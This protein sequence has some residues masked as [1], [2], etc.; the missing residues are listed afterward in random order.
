MNQLGASAEAVARSVVRKQAFAPCFCALAPRVPAMLVALHRRVHASAW[1]TF[2]PTTLVVAL[3]A[4]SGGACDRGPARSLDPAPSTPSPTEAPERL[5][6]GAAI[7]CD[8]VVGR[9]G[10]LEVSARDTVAL[11]S[12]RAAIGSAPIPWPPDDDTPP[13]ALRLRDLIGQ[14]LETAVLREVVPTPSA[15]FDADDESTSSLAAARGGDT[16][17][18]RALLERAP[19]ARWPDIAAVIDDRLRFITWLDTQRAA[20]DDETLAV[21]WERAN[22][23]R[24][25]DIVLLPNAPSNAAID[26]AVHDR[27]AE[28]QARYD[29]RRG[30]YVAPPGARATI[31]RF[32][33]PADDPEARRAARNALEAAL[34]EG[35]LRPDVVDPTTAIDVPYAQYPALRDAVPGMPTDPQEDRGGF[36]AGVVHEHI[37]RRTLPLDDALRRQ[38]A[39]DLL[40]ATAIQPETDERARA[41]IAAWRDGDD[42]LAARLRAPIERIQ[43]T[44]AFAHNDVG[45]VP[46]AGH[47]P[48][49]LEALFA[50]QLAEGDLLDRPFLTSEGV[51]IVRMTSIERPDPERWERERGVVRTRALDRI[52]ASGWEEMLEV[53]FTDSPPHFDAETL[54]AAWPRC[55]AEHLASPPRSTP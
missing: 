13:D 29:Q 35:A 27:A 48:D 9:A 6:E 8:A 39:A 18:Q 20:L 36:W 42:A 10:E 45:S 30:M 16:E 43:R 49:L 55:L 44:P 23:R 34:S 21:Q 19:G 24:V 25:A 33:A 15:T 2:G 46:V 50:S 52:D 7:S 40:R 17:A 38:I 28:I 37:E 5:T 11:A 41:L 26:A 47:A 22:D 31:L 4:G 12:A 14:T 53:R 54:A 3:L 1:T 51:A 32:D